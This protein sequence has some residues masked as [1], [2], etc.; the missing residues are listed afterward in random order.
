MSSPLTG[1]PPRSARWTDGA[2]IIAAVLALC[3]PS[4]G[5]LAGSGSADAAEKRAPAPWPALPATPAEWFALPAALQ[6]YVRDHFA[7]RSTLIKAHARLAHDL[8]GVS[9]SP[10][11]WLGKDSWLY[12]TDDGAR[13]DLLND[14]LPEGYLAAWVRALDHTEQWL[15]RRGIAY[16][17]VI[18]PDKHVVYP[19]YL[20]SG[21][22]PR[23]GATR[24]DQVVRALTERTQV[25]VIDLRAPLQD[26]ARGERIFHR[27]DTHWNDEG[28]YVG[29]DLVM[30]AVHAR[31]P[32]AGAP[33]PRAD[34][35]QTRRQT[36]GL[37][38]AQMLNLGDRLDEQRVDLEPGRPRRAVVRSPPG[39]SP[40]DEVGDLI[41]E[42][43]GSTQPR[44]VIYRDSFATAL[45]PFLAE[46]FSR[47][48]FL[49]QRAVDPELVSAERP[50]VVIHEIVGRRFG[51]HVP[52]DFSVSQLGQPPAA[53]PGPQAVLRTHA[54]KRSDD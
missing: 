24:I 38:L 26:A 10:A 21:V 19:Q 22:R 7:L 37:D 54:G 2:L 48:R 39:A 32:A 44:A 9:P 13:E 16:V 11:V 6:A 20:P 27:T 30:R 45:V 34:F 12:Y 25:P 29:Y 40:A 53:G 33:V 52:F 43:P 49:W 8:L 18:V 35:R 41:T 50:S 17:V 14:P 46:H 1:R 42:I 47:A 28:A 36:P 5:M 31:V 23:A 15:T 3:A 51:T 4:L